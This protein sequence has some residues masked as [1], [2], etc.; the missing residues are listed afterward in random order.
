MSAMFASK[1]LR[2]CAREL[3]WQRLLRRFGENWRVL[4]AHLVLF[5][6][7][8]PAERDLVPR[9]VMAELTARLA[10]ESATDPPQG[11]VCCGTLLSRAQFLVD[12]GRWGYADARLEPRGC[13]TPEQIE[14]WTRAIAGDDGR[15]QLDDL[16]EGRWTV[17]VHG[18]G[19]SV[20]VPDQPTRKGW[21]RVVDH[22]LDPRGAISHT[23][24][25]ASR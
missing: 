23:R 7:I 3:D 12:V 1:L 14:S 17:T 20:D 5:G 6:F 4:F 24:V 2:S 22:E 13:M 19:Q 21:I 25:L 11:R 15:Y 10:D 8:Y 9:A 16:R 18:F